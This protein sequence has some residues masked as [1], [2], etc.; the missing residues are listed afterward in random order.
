MI[1][2]TW[3]FYTIICLLAVLVSVYLH[4]LGE[5]DNEF[6]VEDFLM[7]KDPS[8]KSKA[9]PHKL[10]FL[11]TFVI[12]AWINVMIAPMIATSAYALYYSFAFMGVFTV[13]LLS[14]SALTIIRD[15]I[16]I[17]VTKQAPAASNP[18]GDKNA[19]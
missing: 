8:G 10:A 2:P 3:A 4:R 17:W 5:R 18:G 19:E 12:C 13:S 6:K 14:K 11:L 16:Q 7:S 15:I 9:N 1:L